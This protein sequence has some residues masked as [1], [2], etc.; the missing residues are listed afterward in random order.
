MNAAVLIL[1]LVMQNSVYAKDE[2][3]IDFIRLFIVNEQ[4]PTHLVY[5]GLC[6]KKRKYIVNVWIRATVPI[7]QRKISLAN[8]WSYLLFRGFAKYYLSGTFWDVVV[9]AENFR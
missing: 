7:E 9:V 3:T 4:K 8:P 2:T 5:G 6:W 1:L